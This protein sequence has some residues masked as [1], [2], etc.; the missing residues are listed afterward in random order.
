MNDNDDVSAAY[1]APR[2]N[3]LTAEEQSLIAGIRESHGK[4]FAVN[5]LGPFYLTLLL[6]NIIKHGAP[7]RIVNVS[8]MAHAS[9]IDFMNLQCEAHFS[10]YG[11][12]SLSKLCNILFTYELAKRL[13]GSGITVNCRHPGVINTKL[14]K[15]GWGS[16][17]SPVTDGSKNLVFAAIAP[18]LESVSGKYFVNRRPSR[19]SNISYDP[20]TRKALRDLSVRMTGLDPNDLPP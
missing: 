15:T 12:Y 16:M 11:A 14:L 20:V 4:C 5:Y 9:S 8:S 3:G 10:G 7:G 19:S 17:G 1:D 13:E 18:E 6:L 2:G